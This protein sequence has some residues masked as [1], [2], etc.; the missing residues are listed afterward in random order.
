MIRSL[1]IVLAIASLASCRATAPQSNNAPGQSGNYFGAKAGILNIS[2]DLPFSNWG[3][4]G[5]LFG[6]DFPGNPVSLEV[7]TTL[8]VSSADVDTP[9]F[10]DLDVFTLGAYG[11]YRSDGDLFFKGK[12]GMVYEYLSIGGGSFGPIEGDAINLSAGVGLGYRLNDTMTLEAEYTSL[13]ADIAFA[14]VGMN[15]AL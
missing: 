13:E 9:G 15:F 4:V 3:S 11:V 10:S 6:H 8:P 12:L 5:F 7:E 14:S 2:R 1:T